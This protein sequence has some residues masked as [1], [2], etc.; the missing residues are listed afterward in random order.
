MHASAVAANCNE[1]Q[2][3]GVRD[4]LATMAFRRVVACVDTSEFSL[5]A[6]SHAVALAKALRAPLTLLR[7]LEVASTAGA[8]Q[9]PVE[10]NLRRREARDDVERL[11]GDRSAG[12]P[13]VE[14]TVIEG[15]PAEQIQLWARNH[16]AGLTVVGAHGD[17]GSGEWEL[18]DTARKLVERTSG[19][20]L[21]VPSSAPDTPE[22]HYRR[23][24]VPLD[25]SCRAE[26]VLPLAIRLA[27]AEGAELLLT[28]VVPVPELTEIGPLEAEDLDLRAQV[29][30][31]NERVARRYLERIRAPIAERGLGVRIVILRD[32]DA[33][34]R[35]ARLAADE[36]VDLIVTSA[37]GRSGRAD[38]SCG[39][40]ASYLMT[41][42]PAPLLV[43]L[44]PRRTPASSAGLPDQPNRRP[45]GRAA[46]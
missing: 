12:Y 4:P 33:R 1:S 37:H 20:L 28:H 39:S 11:A 30:R 45:L 25:G 6:L 26:S 22:V 24:L 18:G 29:V 40:V 17:D 21:I 7:V 32:G 44:D 42:A 14:V 38:V 31:R 10:W 9:D 46:T 16:Q 27:R 2:G 23:L 35:L 5:K 8:P 3:A 19:A 13:H 34:S 15:L 41:H 43:V 36:G